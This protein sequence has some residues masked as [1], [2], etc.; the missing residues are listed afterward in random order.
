MDRAERIYRIQQ[1][2][3]R[4]S[5]VS[6]GAFLDA[7][8]V[9]HATFKRDLEHLRERL[10]VPIVWDRA[11][12]AYRIDERHSA[13]GTYQLPG[14]GLTADEV[15]AVVAVPQL[16]ARLEEGLPGPPAAALRARICKLV[17]AGGHSMHDIERRVRLVGYE[18][19]DVDS[20][21]F[22]TL[23]T[24]VL[25][26]RR[27]AADCIGR[28][29]E[30]AEHVEISPQRIVHFR[31]QWCVDAWCHGPRVLRSYPLDGLAG[32]RLMARAAREIT[33]ATLDAELGEGYGVASGPTTELAVLEFAPHRARWVVRDRWHP[34]QSGTYGLHGEYVLRVPFSSPHE[35]VAR[36]LAHGADVEVLAPASLRAAVS[37]ALNKAAARYARSGRKPPH[38]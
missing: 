5:A 28:G 15:Y 35:I 2:L 30:P 20:Q 8:G 37:E 33:R 23:L 11:A 4:G 38:R 31:E 18:P 29:D 32:A 16:L 22:Q 21:L 34:R 7:L 12:G 19:A 17:E 27:V 26:R 3:A 9:S 13:G 25:Y 14:L 36:I 24:A 6:R 1:M 10:Q